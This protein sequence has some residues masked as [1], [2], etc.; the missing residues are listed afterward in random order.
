ME[1]I[2]FEDATLT[3]QAKVTIDGVDHEVTPAK[4]SGGTDLNAET[5]NYAFQLMHPVGS[6]Y[7]TTIETNPANIFGFGT[8][9]L[10]GAGRVPVGID[11]T[12]TEFNEVEKTGGEKTHTLSIN[13]MPK[14]THY[15]YNSEGGTI[16]FQPYS[17]R[18]NG[19]SGSSDKAGYASTVTCTGGDNPHNNLQPY[20]TCY[21]FKRT[22]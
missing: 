12:Q 19:T 9:E 22:A 7:I 15:I 8:W 3:Q 1:K 4:Y 16:Q 11:T 17:T 5:L 21:M 20:I 10:W 18:D 13:E 2:N 14:H 6:I